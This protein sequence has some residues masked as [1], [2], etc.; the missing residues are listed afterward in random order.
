MPTGPYPTS[1]I[2]GKGLEKPQDG[3]PIP[4]TQMLITKKVYLPLFHA[5]N[6]EFILPKKIFL[7]RILLGEMFRRKKKIFS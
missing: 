5:W 7:N 1:L 6:V 2:C 4:L 3:E